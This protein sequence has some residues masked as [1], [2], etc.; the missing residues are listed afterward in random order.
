MTIK[1]LDPAERIALGGLLRLIIRS[2][3]DFTVAEE[4]TVNRLG[5]KHLG[6]AA[7]LWSLISDSAQASPTDAAIRASAAKVTR[8]AARAVILELVREV[9][10]GDEVSPDEA[11]LI[12]WLESSWK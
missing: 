3:G 7:E 1:D 6:D 12:G 9:A 10:A 5:E 4:E 2:D 8:P 11:K